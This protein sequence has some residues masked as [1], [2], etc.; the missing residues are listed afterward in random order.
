MRLYI[1]TDIPRKETGGEEVWV[2]LAS[3]VA[4]STQESKSEFKKF[5]DKKLEIFSI[6][7]WSGTMA[8]VKGY[9]IDL[10][11]KSTFY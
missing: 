5:R 11:K 8:K 10:Q 1:Q 9:S 7:Y 2:T 3:I 4:R 6:A